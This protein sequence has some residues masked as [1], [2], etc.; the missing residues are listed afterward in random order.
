MNLEKITTQVIDVVLQAGEFIQSQRQKFLTDDIE[1]KGFNNLVTYVDKQAEQRIVENL[2]KIMP[3]AG[4]ITEE[5]TSDKHSDFINW[6]IDPLDGTTNYIRGFPVYSS[7]VALAQ[8]DEILLGV[9]FEICRNELF[10]AW[11]GGGAF[12]NGKRIQV[13]GV[14]D[15]KKSLSIAGFPYDLKGRSVKYFSMIEKLNGVTLG[16]RNTGSAAVDMAYVASG[17]VDAFFEFN[18]H[19]WD[20]AAGIILVK[21]AGGNVSDF[22]GGKNYWDGSEIM[23][24]GAIHEE[25]LNFIGQNFPDQKNNQ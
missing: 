16:F 7:T 6:I 23:A 13:T 8:D 12:C 21:E 1:E 2:S 5:E 24:A 20:I 11:R 15:L 25:M 4:F 14:S 19:L 17:R 3:Q 22:S 18:L 10:S 9:T